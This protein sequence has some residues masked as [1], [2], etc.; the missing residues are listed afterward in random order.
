MADRQTAQ[1]G[2]PSPARTPSPTRTASPGD[3]APEDARPDTTLFLTIDAGGTSTRAV[4]HDSDGRSFGYGVAGSGNPTAVGANA[5][6]D[7]MYSAADEALSQAGAEPVQVGFALAAMAGSRTAAPGVEGG[8]A[9]LGVT[10]E[11]TIAGDLE[12][13]FASGTHQLDGAALVSGTGAAAVA[14]RDGAVARTVDGRGW[15][16]GDVGSGF[17]IARR[18]L[19]AVTAHIDGFGAPTSMTTAVL[20][21]IGQPT[22]LTDREATAQALVTA[23]YR[24]GAPGIATFAPIAFAHSETDDTA[25][26]IVDEAATG[27]ARTVIA[28]GAPPDPAALVVGGSVLFHQQ[29]LRDRLSALLTEHGWTGL[30]PVADGMTGAVVMS[31]RAAGYDVSAASHRRITASL[32]AIRAHSRPTPAGRTST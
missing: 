6:A 27:L 14:V 22:D 17:W 4:V 15:L 7:A 5:V 23:T 19:R 32:A 3:H 20:A 25:R 9:R 28:L 21:G 30:T 11:L 16:L 13:I 31:L 2:Q 18:V 26:R 8:L 1:A 24:I 29:A 12:A 10:A